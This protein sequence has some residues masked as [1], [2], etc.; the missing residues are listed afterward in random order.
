MSRAWMNDAADAH[1]RDYPNIKRIINQFNRI[2]RWGNSAHHRDAQMRI[3]MLKRFIELARRAEPA[4]ACT[5]SSVGVNQWA[6]QRIKGVWE[7]LSTKWENRY[8]DL[9]QLCNPKSNSAADARCCAAS[10]K[11][12]WPAFDDAR[13][14]KLNKKRR[15]ADVLRCVRRCQ[16][17]EYVFAPHAEIDRFLWH[18]REPF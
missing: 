2:S 12:A 13:L 14:L 3:S 4:R 7:K 15:E 16:R 9:D 6:V 11:W 5:S 18:A 17:G 1:A 10:T 8:A